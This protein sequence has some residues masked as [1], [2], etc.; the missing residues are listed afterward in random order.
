MMFFSLWH[1]KVPEKRERVNTQSNSELK[2][3]TSKVLAS[4][5]LPT[6]TP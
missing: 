1:S 4:S 6:S 2:A 3:R 5:A